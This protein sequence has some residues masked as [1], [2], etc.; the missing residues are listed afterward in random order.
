MGSTVRASSIA[1]SLRA[2]VN[3][4]ARARG[5]EAASGGGSTE[6]RPL[7]SRPWTRHLQR[8]CTIRRGCDKTIDDNCGRP[9]TGGGERAP[10]WLFVLELSY[11]IGLLAVG[12]IYVSDA[13]FRSALPRALGPLPIEV[14]W[15][16]AVGADIVGI[17]AHFF[18]YRD[19]DVSFNR[20][21]VSRPLL[22]AIQGP[23]G[24]LLLLVIVRAASKQPPQ[25]D[26]SFYDAAS[27]LIGFA[28]QTFR[29]LITKATQVIIGPG[30]RDSNSGM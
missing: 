25:A 15:F 9:D 21:H 5:C 22:G 13:G 8:G 23:L 18:H 4:C 12:I 29:D 3:P 28:D 26:A 11:L 6:V 20:W 7:I 27:F 30:E 19:W 17:T 24:C 2:R 14:P 16:G 1:K 10:L